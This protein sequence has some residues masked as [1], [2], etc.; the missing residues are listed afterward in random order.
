LALDVLQHQIV[1]KVLNG[2]TTSQKSPNQRGADLI[3]H[4]VCD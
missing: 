2:L 3:G 4:P 1:Q